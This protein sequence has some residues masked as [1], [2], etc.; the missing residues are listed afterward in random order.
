MDDLSKTTLCPFFSL[1]ASR[2]NKARISYFRQLSVTAR[3]DILEME[4]IDKSFSGVKVLNQ[5][6]LRIRSGE[7][8]ALMGE[9]GAGKST[10]MKIL[11]GIYKADSGRIRIGGEEVSIHGPR[12]A[13]SKGISM[14]H[15]ELHPVL[16]ME[17]AENIFIGREILKKGFEKFGL[18]DKAAMRRESARLFEEIEEHINPT[19][20]MRNLS[21]AQIQLVEIVKAI[22]LSANIIIMDEP[23]SAITEREVEVLLKQIN[24]LKAQGVA[25][26]YISHRMEEIFR[27]A[28]TITVLRDG[29]LV[30]SDSAQNLDRDKL[31]SMMV[32][33]QISELFPK[34]HPQA[35]EVLLEAR[36]ITRGKRVRNVSFTLR[37][38][39]VLGIAGLVGAGRSELV[40]SIFGIAPH[41][42]GE[43]I[44]KGQPVRIRSPKDA[45]EAKIAMITEDRKMTGLNLKATVEHNIS[46]VSIAKF[47]VLGLIKQQVEGKLADE[48]I[49]KLRV[50]TA[51]RLSPVSS[52]SGGNQQKVVLAKWLLTEPDIIIFDEPTRGID[53]GAKREIY[54][55]I[56]ELAKK[57]KGVV[58]ISS[59]MPEIMG[60]SDRIL[61]MCEGTLKGELL[62]KDFSQ[63]AIMAYAS[64]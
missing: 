26:I 40:E 45:I 12:D 6:S 37:A 41:V 52:L 28:D 43:V 59:E 44:V 2:G 55:L 62:R 58:V 21:V 23:T 24:K 49:K 56:G 35:G 32:G 51:S 17:V 22:S 25:I 38:G 13:L 36:N 57:G 61:V 30:G 54:M 29:K 63:E 33:R 11:M 4:D 47:A 39:E 18:V 60:L 14:I 15:Q 48:Y 27:I 7:V 42:Q 8:H 3:N 9:N 10:L 31:I 50:K 1:S 64:P 20:L 34:E 46:I 5:V 53:V 16:D 19:A